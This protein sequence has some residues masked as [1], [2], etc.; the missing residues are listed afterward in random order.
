MSKKKVDASL[1]SISA[2]TFLLPFSIFESV[3]WS[4]SKAAANFV[5]VI[6]LSVLSLWIYSPN[7]SFMF[8]KIT[9]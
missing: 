7:V 1:G 9:P 3:D 8:L 2:G 4:R 6:Q 5:K